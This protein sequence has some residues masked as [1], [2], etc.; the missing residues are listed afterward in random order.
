MNVRLA[1]T[2]GALACIGL[3]AYA[4]YAQHG[5]GLEPCPLCIFQR[6]AVISLGSVFLIAALHPAGIVGRRVYGVLLGLVALVGSGVAGRHV[7]LTML[8]PERVP[9]CGP[10][11]DFMLES[12]PLRETLAVVLSGSGECASI[13]WQFLG[14]S[15]PAWVLIAL[16]SLGAYGVLCNWR[17]SRS[18]GV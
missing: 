1:N 3:M 8:P 12:F 4:L 18:A 7:W 5:L 14:L 6:V 9:A 15:M 11:L 2:A 17:A 16:V 10:G 13:D